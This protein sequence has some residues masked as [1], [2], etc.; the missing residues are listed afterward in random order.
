VAGAAKLR[1]RD[2][3]FDKQE[4]IQAEAKNLCISTQENA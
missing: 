3:A 2:V 4:A 1:A